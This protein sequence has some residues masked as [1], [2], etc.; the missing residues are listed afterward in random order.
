MQGRALALG[1][2]AGH[3][4]TRNCKVRSLQARSL[5]KISFCIMGMIILLYFLTSSTRQLPY[6]SNEESTRCRL[7]SEP[8]ITPRLTKM[9]LTHSIESLPPPPLPS[10]P[11]LASAPPPFTSCVSSF[12]FYRLQPPSPTY[13]LLPLPGRPPPNPL[14][15]PVIP[16]V[17]F[18]IRPIKPPGAGSS[19]IEPH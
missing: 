14:E 4:S 5:K 10:P 18:N 8:S 13:Y 15:S 11:P 16:K 7:G 9:I 2:G 1:E 6:H 19:Q 17:N 12:S 3:L